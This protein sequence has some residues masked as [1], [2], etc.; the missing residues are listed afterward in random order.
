MYFVLLTHRDS[1]KDV[2]VLSIWFFIDRSI[3]HQILSIFVPA[4]YKQLFF[5]RSTFRSLAMNTNKIGVGKR[6]LY[7]A[8]IFIY[9]LIDLDYY[10]QYNIVYLI[11]FTFY[12]TENRRVFLV[13]SLAYTKCYVRNLL[14]DCSY[15]VFNIAN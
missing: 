13:N 3:V 10:L 14:R 5:K 1:F 9:V 11:V 8:F 2:C 4:F 6:N 12:F 15:T 7:N